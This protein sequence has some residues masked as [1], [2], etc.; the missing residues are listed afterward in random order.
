MIADDPMGSR[1]LSLM[2]NKVDLP[3]P[4]QPAGEGENFRNV[5][6][7]KGG[8]MYYHGNTD[9]TKAYECTGRWVVATGYALLNESGKIGF[10]LLDDVVLAGDDPP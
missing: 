4:N 5:V 9:T 2:L 3:N 10:L 7:T 8:I 6:G 1:Y